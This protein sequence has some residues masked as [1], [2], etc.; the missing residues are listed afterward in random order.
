M[1]LRH[2]SA[3]NLA[4]TLMLGLISACSE[5]KIP[6]LS[7]L[8]L[9]AMHWDASP[10][11]SAWTR[12][13]L[14]AV[15][16]HDAELAQTVPADITTFCPGYPKASLADRRAFWVGLLSATAKLESG[17]NPQALGGKGRYVG[18][19]QISP[20]TAQQNQCQ[21]RTAAALKDGVANL[22]CAVEIMAPHVAADGVVAGGGNR[23]I[24]RDW[25]PYRKA[26]ARAGIAAWT[27]KQAYCQG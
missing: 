25:G 9:P 19:M 4:L 5:A 2:F 18:L 24:G 20:R 15:A 6:D 7:A 27:A 14:S 11:A 22:A 1:Q 16:A 13:T 17:H 10:H 3:R 8:L 21:A 12:E 26:S 23:G